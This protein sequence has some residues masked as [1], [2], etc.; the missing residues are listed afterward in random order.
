MERWIFI[1]LSPDQDANLP[2]L[3]IIELS[4]TA[5][6]KRRFCVGHGASGS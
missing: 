1:H 3:E 2:I 5:L 4:G 6:M